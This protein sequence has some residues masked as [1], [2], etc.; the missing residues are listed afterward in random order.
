MRKY[1][2]FAFHHR[3]IFLSKVRFSSSSYSGLLD[4]SIAKSYTA[5]VVEEAVKSR[6]KERLRDSKKSKLTEENEDVFRMILPPPNVTGKLHIGHA[7]TVTI[8]DTIM[9]W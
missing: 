7:F 8:Q 1:L 4:E 2:L 5:P 9:R 6:W 3:N